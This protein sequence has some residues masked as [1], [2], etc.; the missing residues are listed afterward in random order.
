MEHFFLNWHPSPPLLG[1]LCFRVWLFG[2]LGVVVVFPFFVSI[3]PPPALLAQLLSLVFLG[4]ASVGGA[5]TRAVLNGFVLLV[6]VLL[7][8]LP[9]SWTSCL[10]MVDLLARED[11][12]CLLLGADGVF[13]V[14]L[15]SDVA[16]AWICS[17]VCWG[18]VV[19]TLGS[20]CFHTSFFVMDR[21]ICLV[22]LVSLSTLGT[23]WATLGDGCV[24]DVLGVVAGDSISTSLSN[25]Y[26]SRLPSLFVMPFHA[27]I[28]SAI[29]FM[30][31]SA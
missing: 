1:G 13:F 28:Q 14:F 12:L 16:L 6:V 5:P 10:R 4:F 23:G 9:P 3:L 22:S 17:I 25:S 27:A 15:L 20:D 30:S 24:G 2:V 26:S 18:A 21:V 29:A 19:C 8:L 7:L 31:L 11:I